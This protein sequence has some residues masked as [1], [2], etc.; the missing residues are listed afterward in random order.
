MRKLIKKLANW[1]NDA[2][3]VEID[4]NIAANLRNV[5]K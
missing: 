4:R 3:N 5:R 2:N 1:V